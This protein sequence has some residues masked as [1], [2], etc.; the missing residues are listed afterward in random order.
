MITRAWRW[1][2][3]VGYAHH[4]S[5]KLAAQFAEALRPQATPTRS[6]GLEFRC[7]RQGRR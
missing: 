6:E 7:N 3:L 5:P 4:A 2:A 1:L